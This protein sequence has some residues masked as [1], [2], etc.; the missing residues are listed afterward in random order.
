MSEPSTRRRLPPQQRRRALLDA[1]AVEF[2]QHGYD[3][4]SLRAVARRA[5]V[6]TPVIYDHFG[7]K[8]GLYVALLDEATASIIA[9]QGR[10]RDMEPGEEL[11]RVLFD[12]FFSWVE[13]QPHAWRMLFHDEPADPAIAA[14]LRRARARSTAQISGFVAMAPALRLTSGLPPDIAEQ[15][16]GESIYAVIGVLARWWWEHPETP[17]ADVA[18]MAHDVLWRGLGSMAP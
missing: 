12:D 5:G 1:A 4:A 9:Q 8:Q 16:I 11:A 18:A 10:P 7:S 17:R 2:A 14:A 13:A 15:L 3:R 6:T